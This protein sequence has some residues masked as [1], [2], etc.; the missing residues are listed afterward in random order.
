MTKT[1][2]W[3]W[4]L[5]TCAALIQSTLLTRITILHTIPD[6]T[7]IILI[8]ISYSNGTMTGQTLG[9][10]SGVA[11]DFISAAPLGFNAFIRTIIGAITGLL[12]GTFFL[13]I[14]IL[15]IILVAAGT[16]T[17]AFLAFILHIL[18]AGAV[19]A[20]D[21][22]MPTLWMELAYNVT[23][24]PFLFAFMNLFKSVLTPRKGN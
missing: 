10:T 18:F 5:S 21:L 12:K 3:A 9:F 7:L 6:L 17:K 11:L 8:Y 23:L 14:L 15:P 4:S 22:L 2:F 20:Y 16:L 24:A 19:P 1:V 13:D